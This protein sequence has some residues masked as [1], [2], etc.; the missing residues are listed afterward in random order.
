[1]SRLSASG[2]TLPLRKDARTAR[3]IHALGYDSTPYLLLVD[4]HGRIVFA[5]SPPTSPQDIHRLSRILGALAQRPDPDPQLP[6]S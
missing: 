2:I 1:R 6:R 3:R 4:A 5:T